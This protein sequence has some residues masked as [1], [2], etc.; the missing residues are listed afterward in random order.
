[1]PNEEY[2]WA[3]P[4]RE[5]WA[6]A[7]QTPPDT[8]HYQRI[9]EI[10]RIRTSESALQLSESLVKV[11]AGLRLATWVLAV[12]AALQSIALLLKAS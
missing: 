7:A 10:I 1:M 12:I 11:T 2:W 8:P 9:V 6:E 4:I 5:L 3:K